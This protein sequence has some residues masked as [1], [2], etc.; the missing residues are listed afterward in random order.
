MNDP[1]NNFLLK[2]I[3]RGSVRSNDSPYK[4]TATGG[5]GFSPKKNYARANHADVKSSDKKVSCYYCKEDHPVFKCD[6]FKKLP[7]KD[8]KKFVG[9]KKL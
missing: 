7:T 4:K 5:G 9:E 6:G 2:I 8:K 3:N 1:D